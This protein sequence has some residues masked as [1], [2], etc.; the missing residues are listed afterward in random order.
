M[1]G[2]VYEG[3]FVYNV[4]Q[5]NNATLIDADGNVYVGQ[6]KNNEPIGIHE[7][8]NLDGEKEPFIYN[9]I[10][11]QWHILYGKH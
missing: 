3:Q 4:K 8:T 10:T 5:D 11:M 9:T 1:R 6:W 2:V 7:R